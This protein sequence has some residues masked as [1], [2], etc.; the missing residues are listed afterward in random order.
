[1]EEMNEQHWKGR[2]NISIYQMDCLEAMKGM[3]D[4]AFDLAIVDPP[5]GIGIQGGVNYGRP[6]RPNQYQANR[7]PKHEKK[8]WDNSRP[9]FE[10]FQE[11]SRVSKN[12][13]IWG[14]NYFTEF[15]SASMGWVYWGKFEDAS[16]FSDGEL[17]Y[18]SFNRALRS[19][20][21]HPF[22]GCNGGK[23]RIHPTQKPVKLYEWL[24]MN[25][26]KEGDKILDTHLGSGSNAL[27]CWNLNYDLTA[28]E[29][30]A[31][32]FTATTKRIE[33]HTRQI[34]MF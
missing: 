33:K 26:A 30:D 20:K 27:A 17:A 19:I 15:I 6:S 25:Y 5:Y 24:L 2:S 14:G 4:N 8:E 21:L 10:Y 28:Y 1:L 13:I 31:D 29:L 7:K 16:D 11:L 3:E 22:N 34:Q 12:Q 18:T 9:T 23:D 32:Y